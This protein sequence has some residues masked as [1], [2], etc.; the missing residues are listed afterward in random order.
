MSDKRNRRPK[1]DSL[2]F[3]GRELSLGSARQQ[4][5]TPVKGSLVNNSEC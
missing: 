4:T 5:P 1:I 3:E 2:D